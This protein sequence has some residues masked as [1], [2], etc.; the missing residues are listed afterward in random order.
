MRA[1][2]K[3]TFK[4]DWALC[5]VLAL[6]SF[7]LTPLLYRPGLPNG[8]DVLY[9]TFRAAEM[10]RSWDGGVFLPTWA[11]TLYTGYGSPV[12]H[13]Y[14]SMTYYL[15][16]IF[17]AL[18]G[19]DAVNSLRALIVLCVYLSGVGAFVFTR[20]LLR[21]ATTADDTAP[22]LGGIIAALCYVYAPYMLFT[23]PYA[24]GAYPELLALSLLPW[25]FW[26]FTAARLTA[27]H[28]VG[29]ALG[30]ALLILSHNLMA[31]VSFAILGAWLVWTR[32]G[33]LLVA[34]VTR[35]AD[36]AR[37]HAADGGRGVLAL[38]LGVGMA[39]YFWL[40]VVLESGAVKLQN[41]VA[42][43]QLDYRNF[44]VPLAQLLAFSPR[45]DNGA[46]NG[47]LHQLN[48]GVAQ[49]ALAALACAVGGGLLMRQRHITT[50]AYR[51]LFFAL[52]ALAAAALMLP[53]AAPVWDAVRALAYL[54]FPWRLLG[55]LA[56][57]MAVL[58]AANALWIVRLPRLALH[59]AVSVVVL[60][61]LGLG[62]PTLYV[63]EWVYPTLDDSAASYF[64]YEL[65][66]GF[67]GGT[68]F[69]NEYLPQSVFVQPGP[70]P[71]LLDDI[72]DGYP[73]N[74]A[75][76]E[77]LPPDVQVQA[78]DSRP[79]YHTWQVRAPAAFTME[80]LTFAFD[81]WQ[82]TINGTS[83][84]ITPS[85]THGLIQFTVP[86]GE[87]RVQLTMGSTRA[88]D[89]GRLISFISV[90][91]V[92]VGGV[93][94]ARRPPMPDTVVHLVPAPVAPRTLIGVA[95]GGMAM[96][97][98]CA[99]LLREGG[100]WLQSAPGQALIAQYP[101]DYTL[102]GADGTRLRLIGYDLPNRTLRA[103]ERL[104]LVLY[105]YAPTPAISKYTPFVHLGVFGQ[106]PLAQQDTKIH[107]GGRP[108]T[109]WTADGYIRDDTIIHLPT[110]LPAGEYT[111]SIGLFTCETRPAD[112]CG[113]GDRLLFST[114]N[115]TL[116]DALPL[117]TVT[118]V[119]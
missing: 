88:R 35:Q 114:G 5:A 116:G 36:A 112:A 33:P 113:N 42:V 95:V 62:L 49:W 78:L 50:R 84:P 76:M 14:A 60:A 46:L 94:L 105:W 17:G 107:P 73:V 83:T 74:R 19:L 92:I 115:T 20:A 89:V 87:H 98:L 28:V 13:Y 80:I 111:I 21:G 70:T 11:E 22:A 34:L 55:P 23:E 52:A 63:P 97:V 96:L 12:F 86:A 90:V 45:V 79:Q 56:L 27:R 65:N 85:A 37:A 8:T 100:V 57:F 2:N 31:L 71:R 41:L 32:G 58:A 18:F 16:S 93:W 81:G 59:A 38:A 103:G 24:R 119:P 75:H 106:P 77:N 29:G 91:T 118:L 25:V 69:S 40:P 104:E 10:A 1:M 26:P 7:A 110:T 99:L 53:Q 61:P 9:H 72:A 64:D 30:M 117:T 101:L 48:I 66:R 108:T 82:V 15:T 44:F 67:T 6:C 54:Q 51:L 39:A 109:E 68:T 47:M 102:D 4:F 3:F 43:A